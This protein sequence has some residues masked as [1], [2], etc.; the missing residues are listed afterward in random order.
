MYMLAQKQIWGKVVAF[1]STSSAAH[2][3]T[4]Q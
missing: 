3:W 4:Q 2:L 1:I